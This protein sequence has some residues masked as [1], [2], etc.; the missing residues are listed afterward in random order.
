MNVLDRGD[1][2]KP[3]PL[4]QPGALAAVTALPARF[5]LTNPKEERSR[6]AALADWLAHPDNPLT[7]RSV[8]NR[9]WHYHFGRGLC[10]TPSDFGKMGGTPSHPELLDWLAAWF[11]DDAHGS[12]KELHRLIVTSATY[13]QSSNHRSD[14][15]A[16]DSENRLLW[17]QNRHRLDADAFRD[18]TLAATGMLD[19]TMGGPGVRFFSTSKGPQATPVL[20][21]SGFDWN[22]PG[23]R[24][25]SIYRFVWRGLADPFMEALDFPDLGGLAPARTFSVS[26]LQAL[27]L[28]NN[29][30]V[31]EHS[32]ALA[33]RVEA[34]R[35]SLEAQ[36]TRA[37]NLLW[38]RDPN[39]AELSDF[40]GL[41]REHGLPSLCR[42]LL[43][44]NE[45]LFVN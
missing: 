3:G 18:F 21:Y 11:R 17:R 27:A 39:A 20:D 36:V 24:R 29:D 26:S 7:W 13:R 23:A 25:R 31:L 42:V 41:A 40:T 1:F 6:R 10:D 45:F 4:A 22:R 43:N 30:F 28:F 35:P 44:S 38:L 34:E 37:V 19:L 5:T 16:V 2:D 33:S 12:L 14:A 8:V 15:A 32:A 9:V